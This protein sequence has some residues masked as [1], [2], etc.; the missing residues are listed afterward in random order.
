M[1]EPIKK[2]AIRRHVQGEVD[3]F[4]YCY[5]KLSSGFDKVR[6]YERRMIHE[7]FLLHARNLMDFLWNGSSN[8]FQ[9]DVL[10]VHFVSFSNYSK[11]LINIRE[12]INKQLVHISYDRSSPRQ[13][14]LLS[15]TELIYQSIVG[16]MKMYNEVCCKEEYK[17]N[18]P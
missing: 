5:G 13:K 8:K 1:A 10:A 4:I 18:L 16:G 6:G 7:C 2:D 9:D 3:M 11:Q 14:N 17:I 15:N 12:R